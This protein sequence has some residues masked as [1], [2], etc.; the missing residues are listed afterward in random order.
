MI[1]VFVYVVLAVISQDWEN[2]DA[3]DDVVTDLE[4]EVLR[5]VFT[6]LP[7]TTDVVPVV[8]KYVDV[9]LVLVSAVVAVKT[10]K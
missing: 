8:T 3:V 2:R 7:L 10:V 6:V 4:S 9:T 5:V 1:T